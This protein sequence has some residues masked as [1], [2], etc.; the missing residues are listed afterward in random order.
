M[1][2]DFILDERTKFMRIT[3]KAP[4][5][6]V[7]TPELLPDIRDY[8]NAGKALFDTLNIKLYGCELLLSNRFFFIE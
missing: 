5:Y 2:K 3:H 7:V 8:F 4:R 6:M 1:I